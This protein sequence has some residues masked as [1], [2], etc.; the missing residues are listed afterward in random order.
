MNILE[1]Q[2]ELVSKRGMLEGL[3]RIYERGCI[4]ESEHSKGEVD[5]MR[6]DS[7]TTEDFLDVCCVKESEA[8]VDRSELFAKYEQHCENE[9]RQS[10]SKNTFNKAIRAKGYKQIKSCGCYFFKGVSLKKSALNL[11][12]MSKESTLNGVEVDANGFMRVDEEALKDL[13]F[14]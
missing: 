5:Q 3:H 9:G 2:K 4:L 1:L 10:L 13:P 6:R 12:S 8:R 11:P 7:D 14:T